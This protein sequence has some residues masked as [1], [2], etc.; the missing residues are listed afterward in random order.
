MVQADA[1]Q[2]SDI[3]WSLAKPTLLSLCEVYIAVLVAS[4]PFF[5]PMLKEQINKIFVSYEFTV[6]NESRFNQ[7]N[8][9]DGTNELSGLESGNL[10]KSLGTEA[11]SLESKSVDSQSYQYHANQYHPD[12]YTGPFL[13]DYG[14]R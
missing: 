8:S 9:E 14:R 4:I 7:E 1:G 11:N 3:S 5:W 12:D 13:E 6:T 10:G 2:S